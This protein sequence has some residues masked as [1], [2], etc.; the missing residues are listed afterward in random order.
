MSTTYSCVQKTL[1]LVPCRGTSA[2]E[3]PR[4]RS[5]AVLLGQVG[6]ASQLRMPYG[7]KDVTPSRNA[8]RSLASAPS[9]PSTHTPRLVS[10][11]AATRMARNRRGPGS[12]A[13]A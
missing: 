11:S 3:Q 10:S 4:L 12:G 6:P 7:S 8:S 2:K 9:A 5:C 1:V 13:D